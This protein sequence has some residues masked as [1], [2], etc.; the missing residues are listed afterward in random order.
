MTHQVK[1]FSLAAAIADPSQR[2]Y[3]GE[4][5]CAIQN[6]WHIHTFDA[7]YVPPRQWPIL[8]KST[9]Q[10]ARYICSAFLDLVT[11]VTEARQAKII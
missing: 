8:K 9:D 3:Q 7:A 10:A 6:S 5:A 11:A 2:F 1:R 4:R